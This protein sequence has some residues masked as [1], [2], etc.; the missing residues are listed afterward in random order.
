MTISIPVQPGTLMPAGPTGS[1]GATGGTGPTGATGP[2]GAT[3]A[4]GPTGATPYANPVP[5]TTS[6]VCTNVAPAT[7]VT[8]GGALYVCNTAHTSSG[9]FAGE[10]S[11]WTQILAVGVSS[12]NALTGALTLSS[13]SGSTVTSSGASITIGEKGGS[14]NRFR[15][16][17]FGV[18]QRGTS[19]TVTAGSTAYTIDG[20]QVSATG[21]GAAWSQVYNS[22]IS[23]N[24][25]RLTAATGLTACTV[26][27]RIESF[28]AASLLTAAKAA[29]AVTIQF[30]IYNASGAS[31]TPQIA[32]GYASA[33]D[34]FTT[35][36][37]DLAATSLQTIANNSMGTVSYTL[38]PSTNCANGYQIQLLFGNA[39][40]AAAGN[41]DV[42]FADVRI[43]PGV[44]TGLNANPA[45][46]EMESRS[47]EMED[48]LRYYW[49]RSSIST[50][51]NV[52]MGQAT[53]AGAVTLLVPL[54][55]LM[56]TAPTI[57]ISGASALTPTTSTGTAGGA[58]TTLGSSVAS[59]IFATL[60]L[61][62]GSG[63]TAGNS[64][65][66][67]FNSSSAWIDASAEL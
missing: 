67:Y 66:V 33:Q 53:G 2:V 63:L 34:N 19:G 49:R 18:A 16:G 4:T 36:T 5:W 10:A 60:N 12:V 27:Q 9:T 26:Q 51:D 61:T 17:H 50:T 39:L 29:Q 45:P 55:D 30:T 14:L 1:T 7:T 46:P 41:I 58:F 65:I 38:N 40:N 42:S 28:V 11:M 56:R 23:G 35:V 52:G 3:G 57:S 47:L 37:A 25:L 59:N 43:S 20:W 21:V 24:A 31:I 15:N 8:N 32:T 44:S 54:P 13:T 48:C 64:S 6:L 22:N 62:G